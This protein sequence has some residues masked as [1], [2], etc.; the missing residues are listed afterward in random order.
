MDS[1]DQT[2]TKKT[3]CKDCNQRWFGDQKTASERFDILW[4][5]EI[6]GDFLG[7]GFSFS[8]WGFQDNQVQ[9]SWSLLYFSVCFWIEWGK[10]P[11]LIL[12]YEN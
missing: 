7:M 12:D 10:C 4:S 9:D 8:Y 2:T 1:K 3:T 5:H 11:S 6:M